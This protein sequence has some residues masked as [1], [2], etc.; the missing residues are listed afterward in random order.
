MNR[1]LSLL[2]LVLVATA[3]LATAPAADAQGLFDLFGMGPADK[4]ETKHRT[5]YVEGDRDADDEVL[6]VKI[7]GLI[8][9]GEEEE[10]TPFDI[11][12]S[13]MEKLD[14][15]LEAA[16]KLDKVKAIL[17]EINSPGGEVTTSDIIHHK[18]SKMKALKKPIVALIGMLGASGGYYVACAADRILA[19]PTSIVGSIGVIMQAANLEKLADLVGFKHI[20]LKSERT[21]KKDILSP[22]RPMTEEE[23]KMLM[24]IVDGMYDRFV[25]IV[26]TG[27]N[28]P[29]EE[30]TKLADGSL[31]NADQALANGLIDA[32]GYREDALAQAIELAGLKTAKLVKR[33]TKK[34]L[35]ELL[36]DLAEMNSGAPAFL[37][38]MQGLL[39]TSDVPVLK[40]QTSVGR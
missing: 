7:Q 4:G 13:M 25:Q 5:E 16:T 24:S 32:I 39:A 2:L 12:K 10:R 18:L 17:L 38:W 31:Y 9:D 34:G 30:I 8:T 23:R 33:K 3:T 28:K 26:A 29:V 21:P 15:D 35:T 36:G 37:A 27:R 1:R 40:Y 6:L 14:K 19:H 22:F 11:R 20:A